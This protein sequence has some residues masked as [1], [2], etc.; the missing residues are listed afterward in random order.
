MTKEGSFFG[1]SL[2]PKIKAEG[3][4]E[5]ITITE[6][7][8]VRHS[9][10][11]DS[12]PAA[13]PNTVK[14]M[15]NLCG[16]SAQENPGHQIP[17]PEGLS[18][19]QPCSLQASLLPVIVALDSGATSSCFRQ[20][21]DYKPLTQPV[22]VRGALPSQIS[23]AKGTTALP[24]PALPSGKLRGR[25]ST[26][27]RHNLVSVGDLQSRG[28]EIVFPAGARKALCRNPATGKTLWTFERGL[29]G[30]YEA[31]V[32]ETSS[33]ASRLSA[34]ALSTQ[35][36][37]ALHPSVLLHRR[38]GHMGERALSQLIQSQAIDGLPNSF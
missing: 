11:R 33:H 20:G 34:N 22:S 31:S 2:A 3:S 1:Y 23:L 36:Q 28:I 32:E 9:S 6:Q 37:H 21:S 7:A 29:Q 19:S 10:E 26:T 30:L 38:L 25:H 5:K 8:Q 17:G 18:T 35:T 14:G 16:T 24:C 12:G 15:Q 4:A 13:R 27:F